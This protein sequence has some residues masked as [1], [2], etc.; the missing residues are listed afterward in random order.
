MTRLDN[1]PDDLIAHELAHQWWGDL[2]TCKDWTHIWLNEGFASYAEAIW[3]EHDL[4]LEHYTYDMWQKQSGALR[5]GRN[6]PIVDRRYPTPWSMFDGRAY[7]KGAWVLHMLRQQLGDEVFWRC[8][9]RY[10][11]E[12]RYQ[13]V[14]T[15]DFRKTLERETGRNLERF[16]YDWTERAGHPVLEVT[17]EYLAENK[18]VKVHLKQN[19]PGE[20]FRFPFKLHIYG[21]AESVTPTEWK[22]EITEKEHTFFVAVPDRPSMVVLDP[23]LALLCE[24]TEHKGREWWIAQL[25]RAPTVAPRIRAAEQLGHSKEPPDREALAK[26]LATEKF[27]GVQTK[28]AAALAESGGDLCRDALI[29][30]LKISEPRVRRA[31]VDKLGAFHRDEKAVAALKSLLQKGDVS[32]FVEAEVVKSYGRLQAADTVAAVLPALAKTSHDDVIRKAALSA[33]GSS[34]DLAALDS[35]LAWTK[36]GKPRRCREEAV[37]ALVRLSQTANPSDEQ[38]Q[39]IVSA[40]TAC[41]DGESTPL[42]AEATAALR[43][44]GRSASPALATLEA[45]SLHDPEPDIRDRASK[46]IAQI[47]ANAPVPVELGRLREELDRV[48]QSNDA[49]RER[50]EKFEKM[51]R[52]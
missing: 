39:R 42:R 17:S 37:K 32:Y 18:L 23:D 51:E 8:L 40:L 21:A 9:R 22:Q 44:L 52:R 33:L 7:P 14:E 20:A 30:G 13:T 49:L 15:A 36:R 35:L 5:D 19:Q 2:L 1:S 48:R 4:G 12:H 24:L 25:H 31:C 43:E 29:Q 45:L 6:R 34:Q 41:L 11:T 16:F 3:Q 46:A 10:A 50:L 47:R 38:R 26:A 28:I 27:W